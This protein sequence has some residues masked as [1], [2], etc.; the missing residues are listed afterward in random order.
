MPLGNLCFVCPR[1]S[2]FTEQD[3]VRSSTHMSKKKSKQRNNI[4]IITERK[5]PY[6]IVLGVKKYFSLLGVCA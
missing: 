2:R 5:I 4:M 1:Q 3:D 6:Y